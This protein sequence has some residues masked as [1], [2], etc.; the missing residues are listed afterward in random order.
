MSDLNKIAMAG[1]EAMESK[2]VQQL[3]K[4]IAPPAAEEKTASDADLIALLEKSA[5]NAGPGVAAKLRE[6]A[7][8]LAEMRNDIEHLRQPWQPMSSAPRDGTEIQAI[9]PGHG[10]DNV[11]A[12]RGGFEYFAWQ[13]T[14]DQEP[15]DDWTD[16]VCW[17][18]NEDG[19]PST[20]PIAWKHLPKDQI[21]EDQA[22]A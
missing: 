17:M 20:Q 6:A 15:P 16:G 8:R 11:I 1:V 2:V 14:R 18:E 7:K 5:A 4:K 22:G 21:N 9:I 10:Q 13:F 3:D 19:K 12:Y